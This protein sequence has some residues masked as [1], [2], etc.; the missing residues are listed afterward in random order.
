ELDQ[1]TLLRLLQGT[2]IDGDRPTPRQ[3]TAG[4]QL[5]EVRHRAGTADAMRSPDAPAEAMTSSHPAPCNDDMPVTSVTPSD[6]LGLEIPL[7][8]TRLDLDDEMRE[9]FLADSVDLFE[10]IE[11]IVVGLAGADDQRAAIHE[12][13]RCFHTLK[14]AAGSVGLHDLATL[15]HEVEE[16]LGQA[17]AGVSEGLNN[18]LHRVVGYFEGLI[19]LMRGGP[20]TPQFPFRKFGG[21]P[22]AG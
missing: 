19:G 9:A 1:Q 7:L 4:P 15:V 11:G 21:G 6:L 12:L 10:R 3:V 16:R 8:P 14:G 2:P 13:C 22:R 18:L 20:D 17:S 5:S